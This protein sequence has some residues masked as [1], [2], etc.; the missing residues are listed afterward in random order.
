MAGYIPD[1]EAEKL[2][3]ARP[4]PKPQP[5]GSKPKPAGI[6]KE[7]R[8]NWLFVGLVVV[9]A[10]CIILLVV[11]A[12][13]FAWAAFPLV[14]LALVLIGMFKDWFEHVFMEKHP[15]WGC[16]AMALPFV[17]LWGGVT[18]FRAEEKARK[19][20]EAEEVRRGEETRRAEESRRAAERREKER[21]KWAALEQP[22]PASG[23]IRMFRSVDRNSPFEIKSV[24]GAN[25]LL[26]LVDWNTKAP[27]MTIFVR[28]GQTTEVDV[29]SGTYEIRYASGTTWYGEAH[30]FGPG[31]SCSKA[32]SKFSFSPGN[33]YTITLYKVANGNL[34]TSYMSANEF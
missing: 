13:R 10:L 18:Y 3:P 30:L 6:P 5:S 21:Q 23:S 25:Y 19:A 32:D 20:A 34:H 29:P 17:I 9:S 33:G 2:R 4:K 26:K 12:K 24:Y 14:L 7:S 28:G 16:L 8:I 22:F 11:D 27:V 15:G 1:W 31:T